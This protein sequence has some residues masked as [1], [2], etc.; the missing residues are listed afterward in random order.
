VGYRNA[1]FSATGLNS[2]CGNKIKKDVT[3]YTNS[4]RTGL[5][6]ATAQGDGK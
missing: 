4:S 5:T 2:G 3:V 6:E 1:T